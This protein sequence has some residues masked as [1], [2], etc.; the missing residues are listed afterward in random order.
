[1]AFGLGKCL[2]NYLPDEF[3]YSI[4]SVLALFELLLCINFFGL[5]L[6]LLISSVLF[7][8]YIFFVLLY[9]S[10]FSEWLPYRFLLSAHGYS[11]FLDLLGIRDEHWKISL[12]SAVSLLASSFS[13]VLQFYLFPLLRS[14]TVEVPEY[15]RESGQHWASSWWTT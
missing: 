15:M 6:K 7:F 9:S 14:F 12:L 5:F 10:V 1:M 11:L 8:S 2:K 13:Y 4:F 3:L